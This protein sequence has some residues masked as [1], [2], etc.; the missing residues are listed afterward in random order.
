MAPLYDHGSSMGCGIDRV[1]LDRAF[2]ADGALHASHLAKQ[3]RNGRHHV[4]LEGPAARGSLFEDLCVQFLEHYPEGR[5]W[6]DEAA[7]ADIEA[8]RDLMVVIGNKVECEEQYLLSQRRQQH[9]CAMLQLGAER[10]KN[11]LR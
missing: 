7:A 6:F 8:A 11:V 4:R 1:G 9:I 5:R 3:R 2:S 10:I